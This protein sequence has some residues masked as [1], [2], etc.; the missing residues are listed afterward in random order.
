[1][2]Q[3]VFLFKNYKDALFLANSNNKK[4]YY[5]ESL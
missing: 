5:L 1:M 3:I 4:V 2:N